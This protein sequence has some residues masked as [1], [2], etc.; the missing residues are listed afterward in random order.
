MTRKLIDATLPE[1]TETKTSYP[2]NVLSR[3]IRASKMFGSDL[4]II[5]RRK[6]AG[7]KNAL[8]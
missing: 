5:R 7:A 6:E 3:R 4:W 1:N 2:R 8:R